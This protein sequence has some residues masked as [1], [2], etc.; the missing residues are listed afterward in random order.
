MMFHFYNT[1]IN[2]FNISS[3]FS[4]WLII[5]SIFLAFSLITGFAFTIL[6]CYNLTTV[7][8]ILFC[9]TSSVLWTAFLEAIF[10]ESS[11]VSNQ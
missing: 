3:L 11:H 6:L 10:K 7:A 5:S 2:S 8:A 9:K 4:G 1:F